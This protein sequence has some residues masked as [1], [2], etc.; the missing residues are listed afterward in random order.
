M[1]QL[2]RWIFLW[3]LL[4]GAAGPALAAQ[5]K[6]RPDPQ[7]YDARYD[8]RFMDVHAAEALAWDQC[9]E[10]IKEH[11]RITALGVAGDSKRKAFLEVR[12]D[13][14]THEKVAKALAR[15]DAMPRT[16]AF[17]ILLLTG[18]R[19]AAATP[20]DLP[21]SAQKA[22][23][24]LRDFLPYKSYEVLDSSWVRAT[25]VAEA[26]LA[27][28]PGNEYQA[29][30]RF[31]PTGA[32][33]KE[34]FLDTFRLVQMP[35]WTP[36]PPSKDDDGKPALAPP[37]ATNLLQTSFGM[38]VGETVVVGTSKVDGSEEALIVLLTAVP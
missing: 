12:A 21:A 36:Q 6:E 8:I 22:I 38:K 10:A 27:G 15:A 34:L 16:Q 26:R 1:R 29:M 17:H 31:H 3:L 28:K 5:A 37:A 20:P 19:K 30:L 9:S 18:S 33:G 25:D 23:A 2:S 13:A 32:D 35:R 4:T 14:A 24:D 7:T 11:C